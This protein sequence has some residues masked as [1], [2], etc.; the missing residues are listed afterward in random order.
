MLSLTDQ[1]E[2]FRE[3]L[4]KLHEIF[5]ED[6]KNKILSKGLFAVVIGSND[7]TNTYFGLGGQ[8]SHYD[9]PSYTDLM[10]NSASSF[11][12]VRFGFRQEVSIQKFS[13]VSKSSPWI[14]ITQE[15]PSHVL[16]FRCHII[17]NYM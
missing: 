11:I 17:I 4:T 8:K 15:A 10:L 14:T 2:L 9:V 3:Y 12:Q 6:N 13:N 7:I 5:G 16:N 1:L